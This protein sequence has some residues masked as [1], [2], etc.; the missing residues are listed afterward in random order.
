MLEWQKVGRFYYRTRDIYRFPSGLV[1]AKRVLGSL[2]N[3]VAI[4]PFGGPIAALET[5]GKNRLL[6]FTASFRI[7]GETDLKLTHPVVGMWWSV[8]PEPVLVV[9]TAEGLVTQI[10]LRPQHMF[11]PLPGVHLARSKT[12][13]I[14][15][16]GMHRG[17][18]GIGSSFTILTETMQFLQFESTN[19]TSTAVK[20]A[21]LPKGSVVVCFV[22]LPTGQA[23]VSLESGAIVLVESSQ[24]LVCTG[25][26]SP[27]VQ[28]LS[29][30]FTGRYLAAYSGAGVVTVYATADLSAGVAKPIESSVIDIGLAPAQLAWIGDDCLSISFASRDRNVLFV[31]GVGGNDWSPYE[32][33]SVI[34]LSSDLHCAVVLTA[35]RFQI[36]QRVASATQN[37]FANNSAEPES[38]LVFGYEK[39]LANDVRAESTIRSIK[40]HLEKAVIGC[41]EAAALETP[42]AEVDI[43]GQKELIEKLLKSSIFGRQFISSSLVASNLFVNSVGLIRV[44]ASLNQPDVGIP[45]SVSQLLSLGPGGDGGRVLVELLA[46]RGE[47]VVA[48]RVAKW[49][50]VE[51]SVQSVFNLWAVALI[52]TSVH[53]PDRELCSQITSRM[54]PNQSLATVAEYAHGQAGR[55][56]LGAMLLEFERNTDEQVKLLLALNAEEVAIQKALE[57]GEIDLTHR[58]FDSIIKS[59]KSI[60]ELITAKSGSLSGSEIAL[61]M[62]LIQ[63]RHYSE[64]R[65]EDLCK[66]LQTIPGSELLLA[67]AGLELATAKCKGVENLAM[68]KAD[69]VAEWIQYSAERFSECVTAPIVV[70]VN[71]GQLVTN[72]PIGC[73]ITASLLA[74]SSQLVRM[75]IALEKTAIAKGWSRG[76]HKFVGLSLDETLRRL[77]LIGEMAEA[78]TIRAKRKMSEGR[79]WDLRAATLLTGGKLEEAMSFISNRVPP[80]QDCRGYKGVVQILVGLK[81]GE[82]ALPFIKKLKPKTQVEIYNQL[83]LAQEARAAEQ[84]RS[85]GVPGAGFLGKLA[86]GLMGAR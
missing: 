72:S 37:V 43:A 6:V 71:Q 12:D 24:C 40:G 79:W 62:S 86:S 8:N 28:M 69:E 57:S 1:D 7:I 34:H 64:R 45:I 16:V 39:F 30:S 60:H 9:V 55:K 52:H 19:P 73:Q 41:S 38:R 4:A 26:D 53:L 77:L 61:M 33:E 22:V 2:K 85:G 82:L 35:S 32:H 23:V 51:S 56:K 44:C 27:P 15:A 20:L 46:A 67:D 68:T 66:L 65:F 58:C 49:L 78:E 80:T 48:R 3:I 14:I 10:P 17:L 29:L 63:F 76:P 18:N 42:I 84:Q 81:R 5:S 21:P 74:E 36:I 70:S 11:A 50:G 59:Q 47:Y 75:Q 13:L 54:T 83:G 25:S 31:G